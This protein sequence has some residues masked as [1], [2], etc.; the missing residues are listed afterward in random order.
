MHPGTVI[1]CIH[2]SGAKVRVVVGRTVG[3]PGWI[4]SHRH[5][6]EAGSACSAEVSRGGAG[7][8]RVPAVLQGPY[9]SSC[10]VDERQPLVT[11][12]ASVGN[13]ALRYVGPAPH[14]VW[15]DLV[16]DNPTALIFQ[17][18][19]WLDCVC[20]SSRAKDASRL[21]E[22]PD[23][24]RAVLPLVARRGL[25][26]RATIEASLPAGWGT[27]GL[28]TPGGPLPGDIAAVLTDLAARSVLQTRLRPTFLAA[29]AW[30]QEALP[31]LIAQPRKIHVLD[32][33]GGMDVVWSRRFRS[34]TRRNMRLARARAESAGLTVECGSSAGLVA[35]FY[36][37]YLRWVD[38]RAHAR[39]IPVQLARRR[40][41]RA[42]PR[43]KFEIVASTMGSRCR[44]RVARIGSRP[45]AATITL[46]GNRTA[47]YWRGYDD[48]AVANQLHAME[49][50]HLDAIEDACSKGCDDYEMGESGGVAS[51]ERF[52]RKLGAQPH[53]TAEYR[54]ERLPLT[55]AESVIVA[56]RTRAETAI[57]GLIARRSHPSRP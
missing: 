34:D 46:I 5:T 15:D 55:R 16:A 31:R 22:A 10:C 7:H 42:E 41:E 32:L 43:C 49:L 9:S 27:G 33:R 56:A 50:L 47:V 48:R 28:V 23:G 6:G 53:R 14:D 2:S 21:Y 26:G 4:E 3:R 12:H 40:A 37:I 38:R 36:D 8:G 57:T 30:E 24:R 19:Q 29:P 45:V 54:L 39:R 51:L 11:R 52:K 17:T 25:L 18:P 44:I 13:G 35:D 20:R 1:S